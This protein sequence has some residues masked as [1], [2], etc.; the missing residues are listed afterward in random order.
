MERYAQRTGAD[1]SDL[2]WYVGFAFFKFAAIIAGIVARSAAGAMAGKDTVG[3]RRAHRP[4]RGAGTRRA[5]RRCHL[6]PR[7]GPKLPAT[8]PRPP[9]LAEE[10]DRDAAYRTPPGASPQ[11]PP[12]APAADLPARAGRR[13]G[14]RLVVRHPPG[15]AAGGRA[16]GRLLHGR[17]GPAVARPRHGQPARLQRHRHRRARRR[18]WPRR[19][20]RAASPSPRSPTTPAAARSPASASSGTARAAPTPPTSCGCTVPGAGDFLDT[21]ADA[22]VD[23]VIGP[24]FTT[25][26]T[27]EEVAAALAPAE[28][29]RR[30]LL[31]AA[32]LRWRGAPP[33]GR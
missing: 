6:R 27:P 2:N 22:T 24:E 20:R 14:R 18:R 15:E 11:R 9:G 25:L 32:G 13:R 21:R 1:L 10:N 23:V 29:R 5:G 33:A 8:D 17:G 31:T 16:G 26:A 12:S 4:L 19:C 30:R 7:P 28:Q 3:L